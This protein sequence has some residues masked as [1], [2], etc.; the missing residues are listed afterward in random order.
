M[1]CKAEI[2]RL[3]YCYLAPKQIFLVIQSFAGV[4]ECNLH[5]YALVIVT[6][7]YSLLV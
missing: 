5:G 3:T 4:S 6:S 2:L 7:F 1:I